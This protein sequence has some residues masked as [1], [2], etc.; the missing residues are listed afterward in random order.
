MIGRW[1]G[2]GRCREQPHTA[3]PGRG[4]GTGAAPCWLLRCQ[5]LPARCSHAGPVLPLCLGV[6]ICDAYVR[7]LRDQENRH[8]ITR[9]R[10]HF[11]GT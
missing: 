5:H 6:L 9:D 8:R 3:F 10:V 11:L 4:R 1:V 2:G 7:L